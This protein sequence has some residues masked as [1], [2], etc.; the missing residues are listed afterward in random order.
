[1]AGNYNL[2]TAEGRIKIGYDGKGVGQA[3]DDFNKLDASARRSGT[4]LTEAGNRAGVAAGVIAAGF[5]L[6]A[7]K[8]IDFEKR[9]SAIS[10]VSGA[11]QAELELIRK[12]ALQLGADTVFSASEAALAIEELVKAGISVTD[13][14]GGA[15]DATVALA[16]AGAVDLPFAATIAANAMNAFGLTAKQLP[17][18]VDA[19][20]GA[21]NASAIDVHDF[22]LSLQQVGA[23]AHLAGINFNDTATAIALLGN[24]GIKGSDAG[25]SLKTFL[26]NL[27]PTTEKQIKLAK[28]LGI[29]TKQGGNAFFDAAGKAKP[30]AQIAGVL[31]NALRGMSQ[32]QKLATL[33]ILFGSDAIRAAAILADQGAAG[34]EKMATSIGKVSAADV[35]AK[36]LDN[37]AGQ[38]EQLKGSAETAAIAFGT[39]LL[40]ALLKITK[41]LTSLANA[42]NG[43][44]TR[45]KN[46]ILVIA[47]VVTG[48]LALVFV[49]TKII[50]VVQAFRVVWLALNTSFIASPIGLI[51]TAIVLLVA[52]I[53]LLW[54]RSSAFRNFFI[55]IWE[56]IWSFLKTIGAWFAG[57]F[58][59][60]F[61]GIWKKVWPVIKALR[62]GIVNVFNFIVG[63]IKFYW[64]IIQ[65]VL[66]FFAPLFQAVFGLIVSVVKTAWSIISAIFAVGATI[67]EATVGPALRAFW[68]LIQFVAGAIVNIWRWL[69]GNVKEI[70]LA[71]WNFIGPYVIFAVRV[72]QE[73]IS[74][75]V[76]II[77]GIWNAAWG[78]IKSVIVTSWEFITGVVSRAVSFI[79]GV[80][81]GIKS[82]VDKVRGFFNQLKEAASGGV[83]S[84]ISFVSGIP[85]RILGALGDLAGM[86]YNAGRRI[87]QG[88][89]NGIKD[90]AGNVYNAVKDVLAKA[91]NLLP[92][93]PAK[94][95]PFSG[96]GWTLYSGEAIA[97]ALAKGITAHARKAVQ[98]TFNMVSQVQAVSRAASPLASQFQYGGAPLL[99]PTPRID[100]RPQ[101][102]VVADLGDGVRTVVKST[103]AD[104]PALVADANARGGQKRNWMAP[105]RAS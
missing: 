62:D 16:A 32:Q 14:L 25:T 55:G 5:A 31:E 6:A 49:V 103:I 93:S 61:V 90:M 74:R 38:I 97:D 21:A 17:K 45:Q 72:I 96:S 52:A 18:V 82:V 101:V 36:R 92:F 71:T 51:I 54:T 3:R 37:T 89:I 80:I 86:L 40:P 22:G 11:T 53:Y 47:G 68:A 39:L 50:A 99:A 102:I 26:L 98:A 35:A 104:S 77:K 15:A 85:G 60:F 83:G 75:G 43:F 7:G 56:H 100:V 94:E 91:R 19:I 64:G 79:S 28:Q 69:W 2:G 34:F 9:L 65:K 58:A 30:L 33:D 76:D 8:A 70:I 46:A 24:A 29:I 4:S 88:L 10:A 84:L 63:G 81:N 73:A 41:G 20:A 67:F 59:D 57:P 48:L 87:I 66:N 105:G 1:M 12:K 13:V 95:G 23:A 27:N 78:F 42:L 44:S